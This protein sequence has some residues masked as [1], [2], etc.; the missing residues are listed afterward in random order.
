MAV[1]E[2]VGDLSV[3]FGKDTFMKHLEP[4]FMSYLTNTAASVREMGIV[5]I[6]FI[7]KE[8]GSEWIS[9][10]LIPKVQKTYEEDQMGYNYRMTSLKTIASVTKY[11]SKEDITNSVVPLLAKACLDKIPNVQFCVCRVI[12]TVKGSIDKGVFES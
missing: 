11:M 3:K 8:F 5:K 2:T 1:F 9:S 4:L 7:A 10:V 12:N 6:E